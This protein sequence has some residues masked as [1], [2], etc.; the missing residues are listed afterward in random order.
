M[1]EINS[2]LE[3]KFWERTATFQRS[4]K[5]WFHSTNQTAI[6]VDHLRMYF[7]VSSNV[8]SQLL[9]RHFLKLQILKCTTIVCISN[10]F[11]FTVDFQKSQVYLTKTYYFVIELIERERNF[12]KT[13]WKYSDDMF[14]RFLLTQRS[15][16]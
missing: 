4:K 7:I 5:L 9:R 14:Y 12:A 11:L 3:L 15:W 8:Y 13:Y 1:R 10:R 2:W 16:V 6:T